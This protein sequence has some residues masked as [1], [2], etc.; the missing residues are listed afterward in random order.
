MVT[1]GNFLEL[2]YLIDP[3]YHCEEKPPPPHELAG[4]NFIIAQ[5]KIFQKMFCAKHRLL[6]GGQAHNPAK[7]LFKPSILHMAVTL[8]CYKSTVP[9]FSTAYNDVDLLRRVEDH[10]HKH[11]LELTDDLKA[12]MAASSCNLHYITSFEWQG[13]PFTIINK[14]SSSL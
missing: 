9:G 3:K 13:P 8:L 4:R 7:Y 12:A 10:F 2:S 14:S 11:H 1:L 5:Y 6:C